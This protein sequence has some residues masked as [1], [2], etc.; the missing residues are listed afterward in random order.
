MFSKLCEHITLNGELE[1]R[2]SESGPPLALLLRQSTPITDYRH[3]DV[4][5]N[6]N[7]LCMSECAM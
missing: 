5:Y 1:D 6:N 3:I 7:L 2:L 4:E